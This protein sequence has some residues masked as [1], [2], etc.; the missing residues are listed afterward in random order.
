MAAALGQRPEDHLLQGVGVLVFIQH[1][2]GIPAAQLLGKGGRR[3]VRLHQQRQGVMLQVAEIQL[4]AFQLGSGI[5][6]VE[7]QNERPQPFHQR[8]QLFLVV[9]VLPFLHQEYLCFQLA[10]RLRCPAAQLQY[11]FLGF[12]IGPLFPRK[13]GKARLQHLCGGRVPVVARHALKKAGYHPAVLRQEGQQRFPH[14]GVLA[15]LRPPGGIPQQVGGIVQGL[16]RPLPQKPAPHR[17]IQPGF[18][19]GGNI[20]LRPCPVEGVVA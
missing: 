12:G 14:H 1:N 19:V 7:F 20:Y 8:G 15:S 2:F 11:R 3:P 17:F 4:S 13:G 10:H 18:G 5:P 16:A 6:A 9:P